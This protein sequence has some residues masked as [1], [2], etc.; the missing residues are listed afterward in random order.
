MKRGKLMEQRVKCEERK[1]NNM[2]YA[3]IVMAM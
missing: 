2:T 1:Y 3:G